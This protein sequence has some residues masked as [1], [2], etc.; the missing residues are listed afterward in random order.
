MKKTTLHDHV[1]T[2]F[3]LV[4]ISLKKEEGELGGENKERRTKKRKQ[5]M[6]DPLSL[7]D[8]VYFTRSLQDFINLEDQPVL[9]FFNGVN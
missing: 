2:I 6:I 7:C 9:N 4:N 8:S 1:P 3:S 5:T